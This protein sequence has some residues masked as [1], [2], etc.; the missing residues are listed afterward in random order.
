MERSTYHHGDL[1]AALVAAG[2]DMLESGGADKLSLR[3]VARAAGVSPNAP[4][5]H[6]ADKDDLLAALAADGLGEL[7]DRLR[8]IAATTVQDRLVAVVQEGVRFAH[9][10]PEAFRL[11]TGHVC[12]TKPAVRAAL[13]A[14]QLT[15]IAV[16]HGPDAALGPEG[17]ELCTGL[18]ALTQGLSALLLD[19]SLYTHDEETV[20]AYVARIVR[21]TVGAR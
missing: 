6:Y 19:G 18:L 21:A 13:H 7:H 9:R 8:A 15:V 17:E 4:Y 20:D 5:R 12:S 2:L 11:M 14:L 10:R 3:A 16:V 1:A